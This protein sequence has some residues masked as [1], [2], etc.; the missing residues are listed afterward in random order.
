MLFFRVVLSKRAESPPIFSSMT[1]LYALPLRVYVL[2][3]CDILKRR[4]IAE[5]KAI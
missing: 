1:L 2:G 3:W 4:L 5:S